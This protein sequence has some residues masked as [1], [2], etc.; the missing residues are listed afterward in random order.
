MGHPYPEQKPP[1]LGRPAIVGLAVDGHRHREGM[2]PE[3]P[4]SFCD[5]K[6]YWGGPAGVGRA[7]EQGRVP[8]DERWQRRH[9]PGHCNTTALSR[10]AGPTR[11]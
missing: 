8:E 5:D 7:L 6:T 10:S 4:T 3:P 9:V 1:L 2:Q 11:A